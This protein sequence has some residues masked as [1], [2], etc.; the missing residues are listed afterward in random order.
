V[1]DPRTLATGRAGIFAGGDVV[2][3]PKT[4][5]EAVAAGRRAAGSIHEY[6][7]GARDGE[8][9]IMRAVRVTTPPE[10]TLRLDI[11][12]HPRVHAPLPVVDTGT[13]KAS[14]E[15][16]AEDAA[17]LEASRCFRCDAVYGCPSVSVVAGRGPADSRVG[18]PSAAHA[19]VAARTALTPATPPSR[20]LNQGGAQ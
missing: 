1:A 15:G 3:G 6:L 11:A 7:A 9:E 2:S 14:Q 20:Q 12:N 4:I 8:A 18:G 19:P 10:A 17:R 5:I 13:F 16:F